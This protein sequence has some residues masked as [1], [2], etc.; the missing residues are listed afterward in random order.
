MVKNS[1][2]R[3]TG[4]HISIVGHIT[5]NELL[6]DLAETETSNG[7]ANRFL[8]LCVRRSKCLPEGNDAQNLD[9]RDLIRRFQ[10]AA[11]FAGHVQQMRRDDFAHDLWHSVYANLS[12]GKPGMF[13]VVTS[14]SEAQV[15]RLAC[16]YAVLDKSALVKLPHL[17][18][19]L[20]LWRYCAASCR[21]IFGDSLGDE[22]ADR[23]LE[24][25]RS[26]EKGMARNDFREMLGRH[27]SRAEMTRALRVLVQNGLARREKVETGGRPTEWWT[28]IGIHGS[29]G[30]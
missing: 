23:I 8:W 17:E 19:A 4:G 7:F 12:E 25:L 30:T 5:R 10:E 18:A 2:A 28:A 6:K 21:W 13:G 9:L 29:K 16:T 26:S 24:A 27:K 15:M 22:T 3:A 20:A 11:D 14:R 1:P